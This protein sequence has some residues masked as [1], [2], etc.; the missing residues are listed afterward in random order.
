M[1]PWT[2]VF[3]VLAQLLS[4]LPVWAQS[5]TITPVLIDAESGIQRIEHAVEYLPDDARVISFTEASTSRFEPVGD[6][7]YILSAETWVWLHFSIQ[8]NGNSDLDHLI[9]IDTDIIDHIDTYI[10]REDGTTGPILLGE[11]DPI[12]GTPLPSR[13]PRLPI[14]MEAGETVDFYLHV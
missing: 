11:A 8:N 9:E 1:R 3:L 14:H 6:G 12:S 2:F 7:P 4:V 13:R 5:A 10:V